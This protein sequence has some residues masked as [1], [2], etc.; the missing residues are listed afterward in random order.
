[1]IVM[2]TEMPGAGTEFADG[3]RHAGV[4]DAFRTAKGFRGHW[5]GATA[6][7]YR[8]F[9]LWESR[10]DCEAFAATTFAP[11]LPPGMTLPVMEFFELNFE[12]PAAE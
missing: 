6:T 8:V 10:A 4:L 2:T 7:G 12:V 5:S 1:M 11:R 3:M 9:E